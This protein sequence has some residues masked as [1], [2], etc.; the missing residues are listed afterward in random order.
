MPVSAGLFHQWR[1]APDRRRL[2]PGGAGADV[3][4]QRAEEGG[5]VPG[6]LRLLRAGRP[7]GVHAPVSADAVFDPLA[8]AR[9]RAPAEGAPDRAERQFCPRAATP[10]GRGPPRRR[11]VVSSE[12]RSWPS[13][14]DL[15]QNPVC[16]GIGELEYPDK[17]IEAAEDAAGLWSRNAPSQARTTGHGSRRREARSVGATETRWHLRARTT[18]GSPDCAATS[19]RAESPIQA[20]SR[21]SQFKSNGIYQDLRQLLRAWCPAI[22]CGRL[23]FQE[24]DDGCH[25]PAC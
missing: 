14:A 15:P 22:L 4:G 23:G 17:Q 19:N 8:A 3:W 25:P 7:R 2:G 13:G 10:V 1:V 18:G 9:G 11:A 16:A 20:L 6:S 5:E 12:W 24:T 21:C